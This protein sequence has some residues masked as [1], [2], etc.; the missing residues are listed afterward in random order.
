MSYP[1]W[2]CKFYSVVDLAGGGVYRIS[3]LPEVPACS[4]G[5]EGVQ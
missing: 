3:C 1:A 5:M 2:E 4:G